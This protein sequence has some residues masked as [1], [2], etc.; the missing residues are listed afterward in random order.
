MRAG[1]RWGSCAS[2]EHYITLNQHPTLSSGRSTTGG[3][4][5]RGTEK[6]S[7]PAVFSHAPHFRCAPPVLTV[8]STDQIASERI[9]ELIQHVYDSLQQ[10]NT[11]LERIQDLIELGLD[12]KQLLIPHSQATRKFVVPQEQKFRESWSKFL[13]AME[14]VELDASSSQQ[15]A[16]GTVDTM[17]ASAL[18]VATLAP[19]TAPEAQDK[20]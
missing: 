20:V 10:A 17:P 2:T 13:F 15:A 9:G 18:P 16:V 3:G 5:V 6:D 12:R 19:E 14:R 4:C 1:I 7:T 8:M 11:D